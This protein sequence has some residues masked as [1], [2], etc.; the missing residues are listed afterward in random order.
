MFIQY[1]IKNY[2]FYTFAMFLRHFPER[3]VFRSL[4]PAV[5][6]VTNWRGGLE[7]MYSVQVFTRTCFSILK[8]NFVRNSQDG[9][10]RGNSVSRYIC[11]LSARMG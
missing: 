6:C 5:E 10:A 2:I 4:C 11:T 7:W 1:F 9:H 3:H 8:F